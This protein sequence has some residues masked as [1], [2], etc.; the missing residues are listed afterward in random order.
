M[1]KLTV[2]DIRQ[3]WK[4]RRES[5]TNGNNYDCMINANATEIKYVEREEKKEYENKG[6]RATTLQVMR[7]LFPDENWS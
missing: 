6:W 1:K 7:E 5:G 2:A 4:D 3:T